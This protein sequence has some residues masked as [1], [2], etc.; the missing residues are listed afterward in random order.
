MELPATFP[1]KYRGG[2]LLSDKPVQPSQNKNEGVL[3]GES[4]VL[5]IVLVRALSSQKRFAKNSI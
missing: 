5:Y 1:S 2:M 3:E 4:L